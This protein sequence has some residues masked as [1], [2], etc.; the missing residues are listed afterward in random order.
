MNPNPIL[1]PIFFTALLVVYSSITDKPLG[2]R[3]I[4][5][6]TKPWCLVLSF[7]ACR[8]LPGCVTSPPTIVRLSDDKQ[9]IFVEWPTMLNKAIAELLYMHVGRDNIVPGLENST[10]S[11]MRMIKKA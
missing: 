11:T 6:T 10:N 4:S 5:D 2:P 7:A 8:K 3:R 9:V 1:V